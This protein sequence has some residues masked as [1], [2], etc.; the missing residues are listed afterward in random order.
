[1]Y[2][3]F[4]CWT[5]YIIYMYRDVRSLMGAEKIVVYN[6]YGK[7]GF[8]MVIIK[9]TSKCLLATLFTIIMLRAVMTTTAFAKNINNFTWFQ[10][11]SMYIIDLKEMSPGSNINTSGIRFFCV[12]TS[13]SS[14]TYEGLIDESNNP[15]AL[16]KY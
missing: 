13:P 15:P 16:K 9:K 12:A 14:G 5:I 4:F 3:D 10:G 8:V 1:M 6:Y 7:R 2:I 11:A